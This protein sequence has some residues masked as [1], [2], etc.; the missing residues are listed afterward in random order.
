[1]VCRYYHRCVNIATSVCGVSI[2]NSVLCVNVTTCVLCVNVTT[3]LRHVDISTS[4]RCANMKRN[5]SHLTCVSDVSLY[6]LGDCDGNTTQSEP[7]PTLSVFS[8]SGEYASFAEFHADMMLVRN[9]CFQYN[10]VSTRVYQ[11]CS[12]V[13]SYYSQ[14]M[15]RMLVVNKVLISHFDLC[16]LH[17]CVCLYIRSIAVTIGGRGP[18]I[19]RCLS[20]PT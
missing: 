13:F 14:E 8:Q 16:H 20:L 19:T 11:D 15:G 3:C 2:T 4:V 18:D 1:M 7:L 9:N 5:I 10:L 6:H 12:L 17:S